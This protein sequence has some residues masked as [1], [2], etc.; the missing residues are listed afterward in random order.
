MTKDEFKILHS[1][2][3]MY[4]QR[5]EHNLKRIYAAM[6]SDDFDDSM[7]LLE[8]SNLGRTIKLLKNLDLSDGT[9]DIPQ[10]TYDV[11]NDVREIRNFWCH[12]C[13]IE[14]IYITDEIKKNAE[15]QKLTRRLT[16]DGNR[17]EKIYRKIEKLYLDEYNV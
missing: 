4:C 15:F 16:N 8:N 2:L 7:D 1:E 17:L 3:I 5:I 12:Q 6:S 10:T 14:Y 13:Y 9:L 11:L